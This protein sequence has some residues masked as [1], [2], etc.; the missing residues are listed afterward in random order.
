MCHDGRIWIYFWT[1]FFNRLHQATSNHVA[2]GDVQVMFLSNL[3]GVAHPRAH[4]VQW[5]MVS[6]A[7]GSRDGCRSSGTSDHAQH[8]VAAVQDV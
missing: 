5:P 6:H 1:Y 4:D 3:L 8:G 2:I 7:D